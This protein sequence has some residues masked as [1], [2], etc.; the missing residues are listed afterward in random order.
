MA[1]YAWVCRD[2]TG[3]FFS[4]KRPYWISWEEVFESDG[5][6]ALIEVPKSLVKGLKYGQ[7]KKVVGLILQSPDQKEG[8]CLKKQN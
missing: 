1:K 5:S 6:F 4:T 3:T 2:R 8:L 7:R